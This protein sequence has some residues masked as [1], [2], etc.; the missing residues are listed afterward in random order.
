MEHSNPILDELKEIS[1]VVAAIGQHPTYTVP[2]GYFNS[3][4]VQAMLR[5]AIEE[6]KGSDPVF[7]AGKDDVYQVPT[8][9]FDGLAATI[10]NRVKAAEAENQLEE[11]DFSSPL[12]QQIGK[13]NPFTVPEGYFNE[14]PENIVAG[15]KAIEFVNEELENLSPLMTGL[16]A[17]QVY[18]APEGYFDNNARAILQKIKGQQPAKVISPG[19]GKKMMRYAA[20]AAITGIVLV[21]GYVMNKKTDQASIDTAAVITLDSSRVAGISDQAIEDFLNTN[22]V[23]IADTSIVPGTDTSSDDL[24]EKESR[25]LLANISDEELQQYLE[26]YG[27]TPNAITN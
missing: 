1:T 12:W 19:F 10:L 6:K 11:P 15:A 17:K 2:E 13:K 18:T 21:T 27:S 8:G 9:Y 23:S 20:A 4:P 22:T 14:V 5:I 16:K 24:T 26:Q 3:F 7:N 25:D